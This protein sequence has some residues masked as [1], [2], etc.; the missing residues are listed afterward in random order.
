MVARWVVWWRFGG[1]WWGVAGVR[2]RS[3]AACRVLGVLVGGFGGRSWQLGGCSWAA[4]SW[5]GL[6]GGRVVVGVACGLGRWER[7]FGALWGVGRS[8]GWFVGWSVGRGWQVGA[9]GRSGVA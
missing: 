7:A 4:G 9:Q 1:W 2:V 8:V 6:A 3:G 5:A